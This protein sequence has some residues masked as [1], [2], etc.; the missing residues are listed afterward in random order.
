MPRQGILVFAL[1]VLFVI[2][3]AGMV[4]SSLAYADMN[5]LK[6]GQWSGGAGVGFLGSTPDGVA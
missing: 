6:P 4:V 3:L 2:S 1:L 5:D